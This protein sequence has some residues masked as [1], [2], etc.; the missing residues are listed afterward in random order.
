MTC[1]DF[2][3]PME[4]YQKINFQN[5]LQELTLVKVLKVLKSVLY[6]HREAR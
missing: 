4:Y 3:D 6:H 2:M 5:M 1:P